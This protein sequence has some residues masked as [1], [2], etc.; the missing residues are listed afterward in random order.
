M[1]FITGK[2][3]LWGAQCTTACQHR[4]YPEQDE[5]PLA[6]RQLI[7]TIIIE[8]ASVAEQKQRAQD[9]LKLAKAA[10]KAEREAAEK[11]QREER[12]A[13]RRLASQGRKKLIL[14]AQLE[15]LDTRRAKANTALDDLHRPGPHALPAERPT[16]KQLQNNIT[17]MMASPSKASKNAPISAAQAHQIQS[18]ERMAQELQNV[19]DEEYTR[20]GGE[21][22]G[23]AL[24]AIG[25]HDMVA[26]SN[27]DA[28]GPNARMAGTGQNS[29]GA[30]V[31][32]TKRPHQVKGKG[33]AREAPPP[34]GNADV[35]ASVR[36]KGKK[37]AREESTEDVGRRAKHDWEPDYVEDSRKVEP[38]SQID[39]GS[40]VT[41]NNGDHASRGG[42][43]HNA[44]EIG[45]VNGSIVAGTAGDRGI[46]SPRDM[47]T[48]TDE[49]DDRYARED[50]SQ[51]P[52]WRE[53]RLVYWDKDSEGPRV[54]ML[55]VRNHRCTLD[56]YPETMATLSIKPKT[57][58]EFWQPFKTAWTIHHTN[59]FQSVHGYKALLVRRISAA[60]CDGFGYEVLGLSIGTASLRWPFAEKVG[61]GELPVYRGRST[62]VTHSSEDD[63]DGGAGDEELPVYRRAS[64]PVTY[65]SEDDSDGGAA[66][67]VGEAGPSA[68]R[69][70]G[71]RRAHTDG[72][73]AG[74]VG[75]AGQSAEGGAR[76][77]RPH[78]RAAMSTGGTLRSVRRGRG[79]VQHVHGKAA[80]TEG[81]YREIEVEGKEVLEIL[82]D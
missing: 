44:G 53:I 39:G 21:V 66:D 38:A 9:E 29:A 50:S 32:V 4:F 47:S 81:G 17:V 67:V 26:N 75:E 27:M 22:I 31:L 16:Q 71:V 24:P 13:Q 54:S 15:R 74:V 23:P 3:G 64:T 72:V 30:Y 70:A 80:A 20:D 57:R 35:S 8:D 58:L 12:A 59:V 62:P 76:V 33:K 2:S 63:S 41:Q 78:T 60:S 37:R 6:Q 68:E 42:V 25:A 18:D 43:A 28:R 77:R 10:Q 49:S 82:S 73:A 36:D 52:G 40:G 51:D 5:M 19:L 45:P 48:G 65:S 11:A 7:H 55:K 14:L 69:G 34:D 61:E 1:T 46:D 56:E 79:R